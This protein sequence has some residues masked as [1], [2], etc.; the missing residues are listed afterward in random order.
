[1]TQSLPK[2]PRN[3]GRVFPQYNLPLEELARRQAEI[4]TFGMRC[5]LVWQKVC[6]QLMKDHYN[7][8]ITI[9]PESKDYFVDA[10][11]RS[12]YQKARHK[13]PHTQL[14]TFRINETGTCGSI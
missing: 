13:Y 2:S 10:A 12:A 14:A 5:K 7:W 1:M 8:F 4:D 11:F 3:R 6:P 9:E